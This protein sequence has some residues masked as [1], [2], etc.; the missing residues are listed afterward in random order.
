MLHADQPGKQSSLPLI[1][2]SL[3]LMVFVSSS[4]IMILV[5]LLPIIG[6]SLNISTSL[7][8]TLFSGSAIM[9]GVFALFMGPISDRI[10]R[11]KVLVYGTTT[12]AIAL[13]LHAFA[14]G[15]WSLMAVRLFAGAAAGMLS[16]AAV[17]FVGDFFP[18]ERRGWANG[19][20]MSGGAAGQIIG[21]P[22]G[23]ILADGSAF[24]MPFVLFAVVMAC[25]AVMVVMFVP[26][27][28][29]EMNRN[30]LTL[31]AVLSQYRRILNTR[32]VFF[33]GLVFAM[34]Y[35]G[36]SIFL[37]YLPTWLSEVGCTNCDQVAYMFLVGGVANLVAGPISG[38]ISDKIGRKGIVLFSCLG[39]AFVMVLSNW[40]NENILLAFVLFAIAMAL[41]AMR[42]SPYQSLISAYV[43]AC[44]RGS[45]MSLCVSMGQVGMTIAGML[46]G[47]LYTNFGFWG[48][49]I[50]GAVTLMMA[51]LMVWHLMPEDV[52]ATQQ[53][54][55][56]D[57][58]DMAVQFAR[59]QLK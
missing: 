56:I 44:D 21:I 2:L 36:L 18:P 49:S 30:P 38:T 6:E 27:P 22:L 53:P 52:I 32:G 5:P 43:P 20:I 4:Q 55:T 19:W 14:V 7:L 23:T 9:V 1:L 16:G 8:G 17:S 24:Y 12:M 48:N 51:G 39:T 58:R 50:I 46:S 15:F 25:V 57:K 40:M 34:M 42:T 37:I 59:I 33:G 28:R 54:T 41:L 26:Q 10:G 35:F 13:S 3:F 29:V 11:R 31:V 45:M 47:V